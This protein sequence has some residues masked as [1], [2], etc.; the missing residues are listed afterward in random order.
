MSNHDVGNSQ[1]NDSQPKRKNIVVV[2][3]NTDWPQTFT[4][5]SKPIKEKL[6]SFSKEAL[7]P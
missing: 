2:P 3:Y 6:I 7:R 4:E 5:R 1:V